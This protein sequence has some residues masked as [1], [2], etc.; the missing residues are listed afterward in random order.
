MSQTQHT[1]TKT[2]SLGAAAAAAATTPAK[3]DKKADAKTEPVKAADPAL[4]GT[5]GTAPLTE[6][7]GKKT[8]QTSKRKVFVV[9]GKV[10]TFDSKVQAEK[11]LNGEGAPSEYTVMV[12][13]SAKTGKKVSLR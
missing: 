6:E 10:H 4:P 3:A 5:D 7:S 8:R 1:P 2:D 12:G 9:E 11:F 13:T